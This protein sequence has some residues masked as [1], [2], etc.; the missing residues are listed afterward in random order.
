MQTKTCTAKGNTTNTARV[1]NGKRIGSKRDTLKG[2]SVIVGG[3]YG[4]DQ[5]VHERV[6]GDV[7]DNPL[8]SPAVVQ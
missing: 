8:G 2:M 6:V 5:D 1:V 7:A 3:L 4:L